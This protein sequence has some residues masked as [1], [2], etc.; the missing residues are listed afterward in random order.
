MRLELRCPQR[1]DGI[2]VDP[3]PDCTFNALLSE[4]NSLEMRLNTTAKVPGRFTKARPRYQYFR[5]CHIIN[6]LNWVI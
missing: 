6:A 4:L 2:D 5:I 3:E 1:V